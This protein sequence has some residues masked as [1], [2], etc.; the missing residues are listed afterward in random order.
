MTDKLGWR[1]GTTLTLLVGSAESAGKIALKTKA[2]GPL[3]LSVVKMKRSARAMA[4][5]YVGH[6]D[7]LVSEARKSEEPGIEQKNDQLILTL[8]EGWLKAA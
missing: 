1:N 7:Q 3:S 4:K 6:F 5:V 2:H 8:P